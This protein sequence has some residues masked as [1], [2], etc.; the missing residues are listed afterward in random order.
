M[1]VFA[2]NSPLSGPAHGHSVCVERSKQLSPTSAHRHGAPSLSRYPGCE[3]QA[4]VYRFQHAR[5]LR[6]ERRL[7]NAT[8]SLLSAVLLR[9]VWNACVASKAIACYNRMHKCGGTGTAASRRSAHSRGEVLSATANDERRSSTYL[10]DM[11]SFE[12]VLSRCVFPDIVRAY[13]TRCMPTALH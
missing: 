10:S 4:H 3:A 13:A 2:A 5:S 11:I 6:W 12:V 1:D 7:P 9:Q 8:R